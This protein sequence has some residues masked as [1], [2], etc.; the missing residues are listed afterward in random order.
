MKSLN[1]FI[2]I[3]FKGFLMRSLLIA[4]VLVAFTACNDNMEDLYQR[5]TCKMTEDEKQT[6]KALDVEAI[7]TH[8]KNNNINLAEYKTT[9][10]GLHYKTL[11]QGSGD[12]IKKGDKV[13]IHYVGKLL[14]GTT[15]DSSYDRASTFQVTVG[16]GKVIPGWEEVIQLMKVGE[17][18]RVYIPSYLAY[19]KCPNNSIPPYSILMFDIKIVKNIEQ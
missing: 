10:S 16:D 14:N 19:G 5:P 15:F 6:Q 11:T 9:A 12:L 17:E 4:G 7:E 8:F 13:D 1:T 3:Y 2:S 18:I